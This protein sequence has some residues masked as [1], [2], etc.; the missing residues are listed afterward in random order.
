MALKICRADKSVIK[1]EKGIAG[2]NDTFIAVG[3]GC[4]DVEVVR[5]G[6]QS[7]GIRERA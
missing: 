6:A 3:S 4:T 5:R 1:E 7:L 2:L